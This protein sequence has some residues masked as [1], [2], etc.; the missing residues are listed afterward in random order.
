MITEKGGIGV[1]PS[2]IYIYAPPLQIA[3]PLILLRKQEV[4]KNEE[5]G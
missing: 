4:V 2:M 5:R 3:N 1:P